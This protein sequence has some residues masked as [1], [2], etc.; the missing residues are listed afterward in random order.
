[1]INN[2]DEKIKKL[3][4]EILALKEKKEQADESIVLL[5]N[6]LKNFEREFYLQLNERLERIKKSWSWR[7]GRLFVAPADWLFKHTFFHKTS[8]DKNIIQKIDASK[9]NFAVIFDTF[10]QACF[11]PEINT[12]RFTPENWHDIFKQT[13]VEALIIESAWNGNEG[14]WFNKIVNVS[15]AFNPEIHSVLKWTKTN[16][17]PTIFW[18]KE[19][20]VHFSQFIEVAKNCDYIFTTDADC[21][22]AYK[23]HAPNSSA[24]TLPFAAQPFIHNPVSEFSRD[25]SICFAGSYYGQRY[26]ERRQDMDMLLKPSLPYGLE[27][28]DRHFGENNKSAQDYQFPEIYINAIKGKLDYSEMV[29]TYKKYKVFLNVNSVKYSPTMCARRVFEI[30]ASGTPVISN[31]SEG[32]INLLGEDTVFISES[33]DDTRKHIEYLLSDEMNWWRASLKGLRKVIKHHTYEARLNLILTTIGLVQNEI[34]LYK[35]GVVSKVK[36]M[37]EVKTLLRMSKSQYYTNFNISM[38]THGDRIDN[39][40]H[41]SIKSLFAPIEVKILHIADDHLEEKILSDSDTKYMAFFHVENHYG[42]NYLNDYA[43]ALK[44]SNPSIMGKAA[45][46]H[47]LPG[48]HLQIS[49]KG[50]EYKYVSSIRNSTSVHRKSDLDPAKIRNYM[51]DGDVIDSLGKILSIDPCN[52]L[53]IG[54]AGS[55]EIL[56][57]SLLEKI[58]L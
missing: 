8:G 18:N 6:K 45:Y 52:Y 22:N 57:R 16:K 40:Q 21:I 48:Q 49:D 55:H 30:L 47:L 35:F 25:K 15:E 46:F 38:I 4:K 17:V 1:M 5:E 3:E 9:R 29:E 14:S 19:D 2:N 50:L 33:E 43:D 42:P 10:T 41:E 34:P 39:S 20:P 31:Y 26:H 23:A 51:N 54:D 53:Q 11:D 28:F 12:I 32:I 7:I 44:F 37:E 36:N 13:P 27:I 58:D 56:S 24:N